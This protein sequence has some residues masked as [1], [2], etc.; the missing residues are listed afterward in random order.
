MIYNLDK[1]TINI[2]DKAIDKYM[3]SLG[4][5]KEEAIQTWLDD[6][7]YTVNEEQ[8]ELDKRAGA[9]KVQHGAI[10]EEKTSSRGAKKPVSAEKKNLF[11]DF[12]DFIN[13]YCK[14]NGYDYKV[15]KEN[16]MFALSIGGKEFKIDIIESRMK[17]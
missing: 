14:Q 13:E 6:N 9:V 5:T 11:K 15:I 17:K 4:L 1:K 2:P 7:D 16:K 3:N 8:E 10:S 12:S